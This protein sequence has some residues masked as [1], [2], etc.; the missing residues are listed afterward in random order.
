[1]AYDKD[2]RA[3]LLEQRC[4]GERI[5]VRFQTLMLLEAA[6]RN[7][8]YVVQV[9]ETCRLQIEHDGKNRVLPAEH[10][11]E[12]IQAPKKTTIVP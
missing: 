4:D 6:P 12:R 2:W 3:C 10:L 1:M 7:N 11:Q 5:V 9:G 8:T